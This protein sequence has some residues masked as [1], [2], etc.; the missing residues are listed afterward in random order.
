MARISWKFYSARRKILASDLVSRG[1]VN[2]YTTFEQYCKSLNVIPASPAEFES[3]FGQHLGKPVSKK[4][5]ASSPQNVVEARQ[6]L[7][8]VA[9][10]P[11]PE[12]TLV[13]T[14]LLSGVE[15]EAALSAITVDEPTDSIKKKTSRRSKSTQ[16]QE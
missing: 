5:V 4:A 14:V 10:E 13:A 3:E 16:E 7:P 2:D 12:Q 15:D 9:H 11:E 8:P 1:V 6:S